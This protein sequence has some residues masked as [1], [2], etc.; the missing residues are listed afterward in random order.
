M[1]S[2]RP[3]AELHFPPPPP[4]DAH[5]QSHHLILASRQM[6][7]REALPSFLFHLLSLPFPCNGN[8]R[9]GDRGDEDT[10]RRKE[11]G[12]RRVREATRVKVCGSGNRWERLKPESTEVTC[13]SCSS[14][15]SSMR[16][17]SGETADGLFVLV[18]RVRVWPRGHPS[19]CG[20]GFYPT[21]VNDGVA[22]RHQPR[23]HDTSKLLDH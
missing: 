5:T 13:S 7:R 2:Q 17:S 8:Q 11:K 20:E 18:V 15:S 21:P 22:Q 16:K 1:H 14:S 9:G 12:H 10:M 3:G 6:E 23:G 4:P 19:D